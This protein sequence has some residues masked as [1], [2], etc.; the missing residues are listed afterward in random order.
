MKPR[1]AYAG[2][3]SNE[4]EMRE[5]FN[6]HRNEIRAKFHY[7]LHLFEGSLHTES[8]DELATWHFKIDVEFKSESLSIF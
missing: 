7:T 8:E 4:A 5:Q 2:F 3:L 6:M 1:I